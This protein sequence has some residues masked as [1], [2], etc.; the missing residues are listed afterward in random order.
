M[1]R[2]L[3]IIILSLLPLNYLVKGMTL[4]RTFHADW[5]K[6]HL[7][8]TYQCFLLANH[9]NKLKDHDKPQQGTL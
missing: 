2:T 4:S 5:T 6:K 9:G 8:P 1:F 7:V 3:H